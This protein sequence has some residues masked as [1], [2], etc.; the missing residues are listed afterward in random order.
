MTGR[1]RLLRRRKKASE[2]VGS[3]CRGKGW[4]L[5]QVRATNGWLG[6]VDGRLLTPV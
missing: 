5:T 2:P 3:R 1:E 4:R 6:R